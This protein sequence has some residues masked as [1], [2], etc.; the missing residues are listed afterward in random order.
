MFCV[1]QGCYSLYEFSEFNAGRCGFPGLLFIHVPEDFGMQLYCLALWGLRSRDLL[2]KALLRDSEETGADGQD[3]STE[4][5]A[6][7]ERIPSLKRAYGMGQNHSFASAKG[8]PVC[9]S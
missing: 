7:K 1:G 9:A 2:L 8:N 5:R 4:A 3:G 6:Q